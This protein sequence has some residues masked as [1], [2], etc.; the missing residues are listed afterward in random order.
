MKGAAHFFRTNFL[1][2]GLCMIIESGTA[3]PYNDIIKEPNKIEIPPSS[4]SNFERRILISNTT[5]IN[6]KGR[7]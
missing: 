4:N 5:R 3:I 7:C 6:K 2:C 1:Q